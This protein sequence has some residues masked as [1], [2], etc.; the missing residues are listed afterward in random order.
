MMLADL[1]WHRGASGDVNDEV[2]DGLIGLEAERAGEGFESW[3][4]GFGGHDHW[5][6]V[7]LHRA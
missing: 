1:D 7:L 5:V 3:T 4:V 6:T 2:R